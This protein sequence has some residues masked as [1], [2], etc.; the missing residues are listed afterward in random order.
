MPSPP[1]SPILESPQPIP[2]PPALIGNDLESQQFDS[3]V[4]QQN[5][6][7]QNAILSFCFTSALEISLQFATTQSELPLSLSL[8]SFAILITFAFLLLAKY[9]RKDHTRVS[10]VLEKV[11]FLIAA[12]TVC[13]TTTIPFP[14][15]FKIVI[16]CIFS[17]SLLILVIYSKYFC[18]PAA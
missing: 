12:A 2:Q 7:W 18:R 14:I 3:D 5:L 10:Q 8:V 1:S 11:A 16:W 4:A 9:I 17:I 6:Q 15:G 13:Y